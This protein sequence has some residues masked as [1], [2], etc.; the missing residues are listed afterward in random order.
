MSGVFAVAVFLSFFLFFPHSPKFKLERLPFSAHSPA[1]RASS[2][3]RVA[4]RTMRYAIPVAHGAAGAGRDV[5]EGSGRA[6]N[7]HADTFSAH[8][9]NAFRASVRLVERPRPLAVGAV[10]LDISVAER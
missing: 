5:A 7:E 2:R 1:P 9:A 3:T 8:S 6:A 4:G 10:D